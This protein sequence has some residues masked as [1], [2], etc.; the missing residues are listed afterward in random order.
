[1]LRNLRKLSELSWTERWLLSQA[2]VLLPAVH[3]IVPLTGV[4]G[5]LRIAE[6]GIRNSQSAVRNPQSV[7]RM[8]RLAAERGPH[9]AQCLSQS[10]VLSWL[11]RR[12]GFDAKVC[13]GARKEAQQLQAH[14]WVEINGSPLNEGSD[15][16]ERFVPFEALTA[17]TQLNF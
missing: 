6:G 17:K 12:R 13:F 2:I 10:L 14:A 1:M 16:Y 3:V 4:A 11:L 5:M 8:V 15:P 9:R 7:A